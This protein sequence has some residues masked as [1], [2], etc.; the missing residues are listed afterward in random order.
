MTFGH[1][2]VEYKYRI[3]SL[4]SHGVIFKSN[5]YVGSGVKPNFYLI[6]LRRK[7]EGGV[8]K[9]VVIGTSVFLLNTS[10]FVCVIILQ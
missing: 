7:T 3:P 10:P 1:L 9:V 2:S 4:L 8:E 6:Q 5:T